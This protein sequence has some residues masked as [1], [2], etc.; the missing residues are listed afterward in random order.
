MKDQLAATHPTLSCSEFRLER[1]IKWKNL[2]PM[3]LLHKP[4]QQ[5]RINAS[6]LINIVQCRMNMY[7]A[8]DQ[9]GLVEDYDK[10]VI[11]ANNMEMKKACQEDTQAS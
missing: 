10:D 11:V 9:Q 8:D 1:C 6:H 5:H 2:L 7:A 4:P 3:L